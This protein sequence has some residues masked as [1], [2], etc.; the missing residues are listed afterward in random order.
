VQQFQGGSAGDKTG[1]NLRS[2]DIHAESD[3]L[4]DY[5]L[6]NRPSIGRNIVGN[7]EG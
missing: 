5:K 6:L 3:Q 7:L 1:S 4:P 2:T